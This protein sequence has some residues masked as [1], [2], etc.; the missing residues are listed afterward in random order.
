M[1]DNKKRLFNFYALD[2]LAFVDKN[3]FFAFLVV[4]DFSSFN[5]LNSF[6]NSSGEKP[7]GMRFS[8]KS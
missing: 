2:S 1:K 8:D 7:E 4:F 3:Y 6:K 5:L